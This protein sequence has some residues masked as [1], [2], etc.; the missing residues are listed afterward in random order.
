MPDLAPVPTPAE[1]VAP[2]QPEPVA[3]AES[4]DDH[5]SRFQPGIND[6]AEKEAKAPGAPVQKSPAE[7]RRDRETGQWK[8]GKKRHRAASQQAGPEDAPRIQALTAKHRA[9]EE[10]ANRLEAELARYRQQPAQPP[11]APAQAQPEPRQQEQRPQHPAQQLAPWDDPRD[12]EPNEDDPRYAED[13]R[14]F[15]KDQAAHAGRLAFRQ[16]QFYQ[17]QQAQVKQRMDALSERITATKQEFEDYEQVVNQPAP[18]WQHQNTGSVVDRYIQEHPAG[19]KL[20]YYLQSHRQ[21]QDSLLQM[22]EVSQADFLSLLAQ[23]LLSTST[24]AAG[25]NGAA[26]SAK[27]VAL[28]PKPP[29]P[30]RTEAQRPDQA[31]PPTDGSLSIREHERQFGSSRRAR[32]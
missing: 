7:Q 27:L 18:I 29:T 30:L 11:Q 15:L 31:P 9:E 3:P 10:R 6:E 13:Y 1:P 26:P 20:L 24:Q 16:Q 4:I 14:Q 2:P 22:S 21:E 19:P 8:E 5:A 25:S 32:R 12:P 23:R 28:P 17:H